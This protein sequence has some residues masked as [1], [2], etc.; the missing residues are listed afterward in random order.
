VQP[1]LQTNPKEADLKSSV[2]FGNVPD[3][4]SAS[5]IIYPTRLDYRDISGIVAF[6]R[7]VRLGRS[8]VGLIHRSG[9]LAAASVKIKF[10]SEPCIVWQS[11][12][13][14]GDDWS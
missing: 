2:M 1:D 9:R 14:K 3:A 13:Y 10:M 4:S 7:R 8:H 12:I 11:S 6:L 5:S